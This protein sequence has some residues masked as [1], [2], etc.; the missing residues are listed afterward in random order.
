MVNHAT[1]NETVEITVAYLPGT[2]NHTT[3]DETVKITDYFKFAQRFVWIADSAVTMDSE[4]KKA[5]SCR[6][7]IEESRG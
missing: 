4:E 2:V 1:K 6:E 3:M 7:T 5:T